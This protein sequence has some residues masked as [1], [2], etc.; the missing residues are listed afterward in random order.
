MHYLLLYDRKSYCIILPKTNINEQ[1][2]KI[3]ILKLERK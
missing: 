2:K 3:K 1:N